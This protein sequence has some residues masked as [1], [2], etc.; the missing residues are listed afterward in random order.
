[1][2]TEMFHQNAVRVSKDEIS[3]CT[4]SVASQIFPSFILMIM[5]CK[6]SWVPANIR[7]YHHLKAQRLEHSSI[8]TGLIWISHILCE[9]RIRINSELRSAHRPER[10]QHSVHKP[11]KQVSHSNT[12]SQPNKHFSATCLAGIITMALLSCKFYQYFKSKN[13]IICS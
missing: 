6:R 9:L 8:D 3:M 1:M 13:S 5:I 11:E 7:I 10:I 4:E 2:F 12:M